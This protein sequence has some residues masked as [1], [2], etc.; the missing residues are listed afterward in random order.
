MRI[1]MIHPH[2]KSLLGREYYD[3][4]SLFRKLI[5]KLVTSI[6]PRPL[7][8]PILAA[9]TP[10]EH[11]IKMM[12]AAP[13][14]IDYGEDFDLVAISSTTRFAPLAYEIADRFRELGVKVVL[15]V[16][17]AYFAERSR[18]KKVKTI[19]LSKSTNRSERH[20]K[21]QEFIFR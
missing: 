20:T 8:L 12:E 15:G 14:E 17:M 7:S 2:T 9:L 1:L 21:T 6:D 10:E 3:N 5:R 4:P 11:E 18:K 13:D 19:L 16:Y